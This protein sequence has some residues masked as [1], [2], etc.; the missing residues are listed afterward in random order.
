MPY[1]LVLFPNSPIQREN[2]RGIILE[3]LLQC[4][5][6]Q[7]VVFFYSGWGPVRVRIHS[8]VKLWSNWPLR[9]MKEKG[10]RQS[11][12]LAILKIYFPKS[13]GAGS[14]KKIRWNQFR[15]FK[16]L[17]FVKM[18]VVHPLRAHLVL[19]SRAA[20]GTCKPL[21]WSRWQMLWQTVWGGPGGTWMGFF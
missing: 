15:V 7:V 6:S 20:K 13:Y 17:K 8:W 3:T 19:S 12:I 14:A 5:L 18:L 16:K 11:L 4:I 2:W 10:M 1:V 9:S 21:T